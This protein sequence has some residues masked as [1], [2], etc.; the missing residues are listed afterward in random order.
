MRMYII[1]ISHYTLCVF[2]YYFAAAAAAAAAAGARKGLM[3]WVKKPSH[4]V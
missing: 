4:L 3:E 2:P 1:Y